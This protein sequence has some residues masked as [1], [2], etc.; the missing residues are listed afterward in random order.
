MTGRK[1]SAVWTHFS[2]T[3][4]GPI[5]SCNICK[6]NISF[7]GGSTAN[8]HRHLRTR[9]P[10]V[11]PCEVRR[12]EEAL[13]EAHPGSSQPQTTSG[14]SRG[15]G[16]A[17]GQ[18]R[19]NQF[20]SR[21][22]TPQRQ[23]TLDEQLGPPLPFASLRLLLSPVRL[24]S[25]AIWHTVQHHVV[26][27]YGMLEE[28][29]SMV[30]DLV[31]ELLSTEQKTQLLL[32][33]RAR[34]G[35]PG[36]FG[37]SYDDQALVNVT[38]QFLSR[39]E[40]L[41]PLQT[42]QQ[43]ALMLADI[44]SALE[45]CLKSVSHR[46]ELQTLLGC[47]KGLLDKNGCPLDGA[48]ETSALH[49]CVGDEI[50]AEK[51]H[52]ARS[53]PDVHRCSSQI[54][55]PHASTAVAM[56]E[57][58]EAAVEKEAVEGMSSQEFMDAFGK[59]CLVLLKRLEDV[60]AVQRRAV[61]SNRGLK[62]ILLQGKNHRRKMTSEQVLPRTQR[63]IPDPSKRIS[64]DPF[65]SVTYIVVADEDVDSVGSLDVSSD[66]SYVV[67]V[68]SDSGED[69]LSDCSNTDRSFVKLASPKEG[70]KPLVTRKKHDTEKIGLSVPNSTSTTKGLCLICNKHVQTDMKEHMT[71][72]FPDGVL[73]CP[74]CDMV[75]KNMH[76]LKLHF[77][78]VCFDQLQIESQ[79]DLVRLYQCD[80]C[81]KSFKY[82]IQLNK[83]KLVHSQLYC[84]ICERVVRDAETLARH[85]VSHKPFQ[86]TLC[87]KNFGI[88][89]HLA[90]HCKNVHQLSKP[91]ECH[92]CPKVFSKFN[93]FIGHEWQHTG[94]LPFQCSQCSM[95]FKQDAELA[96]HL[97]VH[98]HEKPFLCKDCGKRYACNS[99]LTRHSRMVHN[100][101]SKVQRSLGSRR[102]KEGARQKR[103]QKKR[104]M[105]QTPGP[106][107]YCGTVLHS[108]R[109]C[110]QMSLS[111]N[112]SS[113]PHEMEAKDGSNI[114]KH[115]GELVSL[116]QAPSHVA[117]SQ[118]NFLSS[119]TDRS[120]VAL[121]DHDEGSVALKE[122]DAPLG[123]I[124]AANKTNSS[125]Q[126]SLCFLC[127]KH[128]QL[129]IKEH[130][131][132][133]FPDGV[134][135]CPRCDALFKSMGSLRMHFKRVCVEQLQIEP[136]EDRVGHG[137]FKCDQCEKS[138]RYK[139]ALDGHKRTHNQLYCEVCRRVLR[140]A[141]TLARHKVS[142]TPFQCTLCEKDFGNFKQ[143]SRHYESTHKLSKP[144]KCHHCPKVFSKLG[145]YIRHEW[146]HTGQL[147]FQCSHCAMKFKQ[148]TDLAGHLRVHT[149]EKP[150]LCTDCGKTFSS[151][152]NLCRHV[153]FRHSESREIRRFTC[154]Q[155][156]KTFKEKGAL[157]K[158]EQRK[159]QNHK[160]VRHPCTYC[161]K[162]LSQS[163]MAGHQM[164]HTGE[165]P[166]KC[167]IPGCD[168]RFRSTSGLKN[169]SLLHHT[170]ERPFECNTCGKGFIRAS[171]LKQHME[172]HTG[173]KNHV[174]LVCGKA[175]RKAYSMARHVKLVHSPR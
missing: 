46:G 2:Q 174:C 65:P 113:L 42:I 38:W 72:H 131:K 99:N 79:G 14:D 167:H 171:I 138:Y 54:E 145:F 40:K 122:Q 115:H 108:S 23:E 93:I 44:P 112:Q 102:S 67:P 158:H 17:I 127:K 161:G 166:L 165:K 150:Y 29:V 3:T 119:S 156:S 116:L 57:D 169:H 155:C 141:E 76:S 35:I 4:E 1:K 78:R 91:Y 58:M 164:I 41:F 170:P 144:Y 80:G 51:G 27:D 85:K 95:T 107:K 153:K 125:T 117:P 19:L 123:K 148:D 130:M 143:L 26:S 11:R 60:P 92:H 69:S 18:T 100:E 86:C 175:F 126:R 55:G 154:T 39:L 118:E 120:S 15:R 163:W 140:D 97:R 87:E 106:C 34:N 50:K 135:T 74:R 105:R 32:G 173:E 59:D 146:K 147:P 12:E 36:E 82:R 124:P 83:H 75:C 66:V 31:P 88:F 152:S 61:R 53:L 103:H 64:I 157:Q 137:L 168:Q 134:L 111:D 5:G 96:I 159:H 84:E 68:G 136:G 129:D 37:C 22:M 7:R 63:L 52:Q 160:K 90:S 20:M 25:G 48:R 56:S 139:L 110:P 133:H 70:K 132:T 45:E 77:K 73:T 30:T 13:S 9:H 109:L 172:I 47:R 21:P 16:Q 142:H 101:S 104:Q 162:M 128:V 81:E 43:V 28:F 8:L 49:L 6:A 98:T 71:A 149:H 121:Y 33:L 94:Q 114:E 24:V 151:S 62:R 89:K 10:W